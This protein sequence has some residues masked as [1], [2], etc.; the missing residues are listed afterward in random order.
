MNAALLLPAALAA[1]AALLLPLLIH[2]AR[3]SEQRPTDFA[4][5]RWLRQKPKPRHRVRFDEWPL[6]IARLL[7]LAL[8]ALWLAKPVLFG[9]ASEAPWV[10]VMPGIDAAQAR[11]SIDDDQARLHWLAPGF[12]DLD[13]PAPTSGVPAFASLLRQLDSELPAAVKLSVLVP[14]RLQGADAQRPQLSRAVEW[15]VLPGAMPAPKPAA[16]GAPALTVRYAQNREDGLRYLR[17]AASVWQPAAPTAAFVAEPT[18]QALPADA[19]YL[20]WLAPG[21]LPAAVGDWIRRGGTAL[22]AMDTE[23]RLPA[24]ATVYWRDEVGAPLVEGAALG[25]GRVLRFTRAFAPETM[26]QLLQPDFPRNLRNMLATPAPEPARVL[27]QDYAPVTGG[28]AYPQAPRDLQPWL[29][30]LIAMLLLMERWLATR[31]SR[32]VSP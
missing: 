32:G 14:E 3:R 13:R 20:I 2:L 28:A 9:S 25:R 22:L 30:L 18:T 12:P 23:Y 11:A 10:A 26:P 7:L 4:A 1:F 15:K 29:A 16:I 5:L 21:P 8:L 31:R 27:A 17:A 6:L 24:P 19:R